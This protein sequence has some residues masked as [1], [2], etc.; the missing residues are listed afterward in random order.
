M[1]FTA[2]LG[3][4][5]WFEEDMLFDTRVFDIDIPEIVVGELDWI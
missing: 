4:E 3:A 1:G 5:N 2:P